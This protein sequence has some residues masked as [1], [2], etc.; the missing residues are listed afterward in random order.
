[1]Y[2]VQSLEEAVQE[3]SLDAST[4][5]CEPPAHSVISVPHSHHDNDDGAVTTCRL[6]STFAPASAELLSPSTSFCGDVPSRPLTPLTPLNLSFQNASSSLPS[7]PKSTSNNSLKP[8]DDI[9]I[10]DD[11]SS[12]AIASGDEDNGPGEAPTSNPDG[13]SQ[14]IMPCLRMPSRRPFTERGKAMGRLK[15]V[16]AGASGESHPLIRNIPAAWGGSGLTVK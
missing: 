11:L 9:S 1:M 2:G 5:Y 6:R 12:Q 3:A 16:I 13:I 15:V 7:S 8:L 10:S 14:F 4:Y